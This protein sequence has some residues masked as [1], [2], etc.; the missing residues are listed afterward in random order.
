LPFFNLL[1][2]LGSLLKA[3]LR[4]NSQIKP[5]KQSGLIQLS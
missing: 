4:L 1:S 2:S 5:L 3:Q